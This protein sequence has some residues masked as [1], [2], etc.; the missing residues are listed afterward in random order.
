MDRTVGKTQQQNLEEF[1][2]IKRWLDAISKRPATVCAYAKAKPYSNQPAMTEEAKKILFGQTA[3]SVR[4]H[5]N[6]T[7]AK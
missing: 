3:A 6:P 7:D 2:S 1:Q 5:V 4:S